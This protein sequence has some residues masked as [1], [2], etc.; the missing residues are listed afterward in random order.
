MATAVGLGKGV[1]EVNGSGRALTVTD[2][3]ALA[4]VLDLGKVDGSMKALGT[5][6]IAVSDTEADKLGLRTGSTARLTFTDGQERT[7]TVRAV[8]GQPELAGDYVITRQAWAPHRGQDSDSLVAVSF[9]DGVSAAYGRS[10]VE[11]AAAAYGNP[12]VQSRGE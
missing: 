8:Y 10:A 3:A 7:F 5:N 2:P 12:E 9:K 11:K 6:G 1:A 4:A